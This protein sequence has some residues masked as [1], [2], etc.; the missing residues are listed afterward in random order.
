MKAFFKTFKTSLLLAVFILSSFVLF[1]K[2][3]SNYGS[4]IESE[5]YYDSESIDDESLGDSNRK[6]VKLNRNPLILRDSA[7]IA[8]KD[9]TFSGLVKRVG[10]IICVLLVILAM[11]K[12]LLSKNKFGQPGSLLDELAQKVTGSFSGFSG[13][14]TLKLKQTLMLTPGQNIYLVEI[15]GKKLLLGG[16]QQGGVQFL[17][18]LTGAEGKNL[19]IKHSVMNEEELRNQTNYV[20]NGQPLKQ[21]D[22]SKNA[23]DIPFSTQ[24]QLAVKEPEQEIFEEITNQQSVTA[25]KQPFKK[26]ANF[27][28]SLSLSNTK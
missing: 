27:R 15:E 12:F 14:Q 19:L 10:I 13:L 6:P 25:F 22:F 21:F 20:S 11:A 24:P 8:N 17:A 5:N 2:A 4:D 3:E 18:D 1:A 26:R 28:Q 16:T 7:F 23:S 9:E